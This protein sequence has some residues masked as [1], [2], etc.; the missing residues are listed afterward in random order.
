MMRTRTDTKPTTIHVKVI[1]VRKAG[2]VRWRLR[3]VINVTGQKR[4]ERWRWLAPHEEATDFTRERARMQF[5]ADLSAETHAITPDSFRALAEQFFASPEAQALASGSRATLRRHIEHDVHPVLGPIRPGEI[6][7]Q[8]CHQ[9]IARAMANGY[10]TNSL[11]RIRFAMSKVMTWAE[12]GGRMQDNPSKRLPRIEKARG[13]AA[14]RTVTPEQYAAALQRSE[15][16]PWHIVLQLLAATW[17]RRGELCGLQWTDIDFNQNVISVRRSIAQIGARCEVKAPKTR[18]GLRGIAI[19]QSLADEL[20]A[21]KEKVAKHVADTAGRT[22]VE[23]DYVFMRPDGGHYLPT[24]VSHAVSDILRAVGCAVGI[25][26][27]ALRHTGATRAMAKNV[28]PRVVADRLGH[29]SV[30]TTLDLYVHPNLAEQRAL[31]ELMEC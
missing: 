27:H 8:H 21:Q 26:S 24:T 23:S 5:H 25:A 31:A 14:T 17:M 1:E 29:S 7:V 4:D 3:A 11:R 10:A 15:G 30:T 22:M 28:N 13:A 16:T 9:V 2:R 6:T 12:V 18:A 19:T 20:R